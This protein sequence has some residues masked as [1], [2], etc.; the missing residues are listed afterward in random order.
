MAGPRSARGT[1]RARS[2]SLEKKESGLSIS[3]PKPRA[4]SL[5]GMPLASACSAPVLEARPT[6][7][8]ALRESRQHS[9]VL[10]CSSSGRSTAYLPPGQRKLRAAGSE[11]RQ[12]HPLFPISAR[13]PVF[14][15]AA[16][17]VCDERAS[18]EPPGIPPDDCAATAAHAP[19]CIP[20]CGP[21]RRARE[22]LRQGATRIA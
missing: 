18:E 20:S 7:P 12:R 14:T 22:A 6:Q 1:R 19:S 9:I 3:T 5:A 4:S 21:A 11:F 17:A 2:G 16:P 8:H 15:R 10:W 13:L